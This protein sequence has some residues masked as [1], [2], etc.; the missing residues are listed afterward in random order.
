MLWLLLDVTDKFFYE[1]FILG[2]IQIIPPLI[3]LS[4]RGKDILD[5]LGL[6]ER[7]N[8]IVFLIFLVSFLSIIA[9][10]KYLWNINVRTRIISSLLLAPIIEEIFFRGYLQE[11]LKDILHTGSSSFLLSFKNSFESWLVKRHGEK[12]RRHTTLIIAVIITSVLFSLLH[13]PK[14]GIEE[15]FL[16]Y[17]WILLGGFFFGVIMEYKKS[18]T[19]PI[20]LHSWHNSAFIFNKFSLNHL[21]ISLVTG[22]MFILIYYCRKLA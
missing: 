1:W 13:W 19:Y 11:N 9:S 7:K 14:Y 10:G 4:F 18:I 17:P 6:R 15:G 16:I 5:R 2:S 22:W 8:I 21:A 12:I 20:I 3:L